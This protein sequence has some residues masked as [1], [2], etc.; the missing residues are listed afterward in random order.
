MDIKVL[1]LCWQVVFKKKPSLTASQKVET[2]LQEILC[3]I[4]NKLFPDP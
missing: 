1:L 3:V 4:L 2:D